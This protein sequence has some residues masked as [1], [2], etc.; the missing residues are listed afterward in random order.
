MST[1]FHE[2]RHAYRAL[3][4]RPLATLLAVAAIALGIGAN[5]ALFSAVDAVLLR[6]FPFSEPDRLYVIWETDQKRGMNRAEVSYPNFDDWRKQ[7]KSFELLA[8]MPNAVSEQFV[9]TGAAEPTR[10]RGVSVSASFFDLLGTKP[11]LGRGLRAEDDRPE[12][13]RVV[14]LSHGLWQRQFG[15]AP[16]VLGR[17]ITLDGTPFT[18]VG[19]MSPA[20][21]YPRGAELWTPI[22]PSQPQ[23]VADRKVGWLQVVGRLRPGV[24]R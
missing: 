5:A 12:A 10:F 4:K 13:Q 17:V 8:A 21:E 23:Y 24:D 2:I 16:D 11:V 14:V 7:A 9:L 1:L 3:R 6:P 22:V 20:F 18:I 15:G 19:V